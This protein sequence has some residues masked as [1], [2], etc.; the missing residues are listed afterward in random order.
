M[1]HSDKVFIG[2]IMLFTLAFKALDLNVWKYD[3]LRVT[4]SKNYIRNNYTGA[5]EWIFFSKSIR[6]I[7]IVLPIINFFIL[8]MFIAEAGVMYLAMDHYEVR[9][10]IAV[11]TVVFAVCSF[12]TTFMTIHN[13]DALGIR[14]KGNRVNYGERIITAVSFTAIICFL[15]FVKSRGVFF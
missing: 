8:L 5:G 10:Y 7:G 14:V 6:E 3:M 12:I 13:Y 9:F 2:F 1:I 11:I 4:H 15:A